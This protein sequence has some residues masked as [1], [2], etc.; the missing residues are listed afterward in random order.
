MKITTCVHLCVYPSIVPNLT[1]CV[2]ISS[3]AALRNS[4]ETQ[5]GRFAL[6]HSRGKCPA[7]MEVEEE[8]YV[9]R[10]R[11]PFPSHSSNSLDTSLNDTGFVRK[12][13]TPDVSA[14]DSSRELLSPVKAMM[15]ADSPSRSFSR[16]RMARVASNPSITGIDMSENN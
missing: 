15:M 16:A 6:E 8:G 12:R 13:S 5:D 14:L 9:H 1:I 2:I 3:R 11:S 7:G 4:A 10:A